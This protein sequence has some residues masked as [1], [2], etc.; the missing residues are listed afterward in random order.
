[1]AARLLTGRSQAKQTRVP[2]AGRQGVAAVAGCLQAGSDHLGVVADRALAPATVDRLE[3][4]TP[5]R[6]YLSTCCDLLISRIGGVAIGADRDL[7]CIAVYATG[8][9]IS[10][11]FS[12]SHGSEPIHRRANAS[13]PESA[14]I[15][16]RHAS[17][18]PRAQDALGV[19][20]LV[21][22]TGSGIRI[23]W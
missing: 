3:R 11:R 15:A 23:P 1:M 5:L 16:R 8:R 12:W 20:S 9:D 14:L 18:V 6:A 22:G 2:V 10:N 13:P 17:T 4:V 19:S 7:T 21:S